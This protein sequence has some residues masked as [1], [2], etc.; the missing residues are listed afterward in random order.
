MLHVALPVSAVNP[1][2]FARSVPAAAR[3]GRASQGYARVATGITEFRRSDHSISG[4]VWMTQ[5]NNAGRPDS[6]R[7][8]PDERPLP[9]SDLLRQLVALER[10]GAGPPQ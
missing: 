10:S 8:P 5:C 6:I 7:T 4:T 1:E 2:A 9:A 3:S